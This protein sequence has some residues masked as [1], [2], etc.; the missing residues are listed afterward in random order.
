M[1]PFSCDVPKGGVEKSATLIANNTAIQE[2]FKVIASNFIEMYRKKAFLHWYTMEGMDEMEFSETESNLSELITE[3][4]EY[5][6]YGDYDY[7]E[8]DEDAD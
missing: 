3:Y 6:M 8:D 5:G 7:I 2:T 4:Q 1:A